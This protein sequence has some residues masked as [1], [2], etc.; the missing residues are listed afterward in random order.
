MTTYTIEPERSTL[1]GHFSRTMSPVITVDSGDTVRFRTLDADWVTEFTCSLDNPPTNLESMGKN[2]EPRTFP[3]DEGHA[4]CGPVAIRG[5]KPGMML[6]IHFN[7]I[8]PGAWGWTYPWFYTPYERKHEIP[9]ILW[10]L[11]A[12]RMTGRNQFGHTVA[13][14]PFM[15]VIGMPSDVEG[16]QATKPPRLH[17]GNLDCKA[18]VA[19]STLYLPI[20]VEGGLFSLGDGHAAQGDGE[21]GGTAIEC[22]MSLVDVTLE[23]V[24]NPLLNTPYAD[25][26]S[27]WLTMG[28]DQNLQFA[29]DAAVRAMQLFIAK[30][31]NVN[32]K[33]AHGLMGVV[34]DMRVTQSV[35]SVQGVH[36]ILP[37][38]ALR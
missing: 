8:V 24:E 36:A 10:Q 23:L 31:Y 5:A 21:T 7:R 1:H 22:P 6:A 12:E 19:G 25:T 2:F 14:Q 28:F 15:G 11:D 18:L 35:N 32:E 27:G 33:V 3:E 26:P 4:L 17:G 16:Q 9:M 37:H 29:H 38:G 30:R 34:A 13:L 20:A